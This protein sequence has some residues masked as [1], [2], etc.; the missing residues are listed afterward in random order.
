MDEVVKALRAAGCVWAEEEAEQLRRAALDLARRRDL[1]A[2]P[3]LA[4]L[5]ARRVAGS[6]WSTS[7]VGCASST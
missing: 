2:A 4:A 6:R 3:V 5:V 1:R 7:R